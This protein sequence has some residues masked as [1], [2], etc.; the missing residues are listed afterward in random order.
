MK[1]A[2]DRPS[3]PTPF[4]CHPEPKAKDLVPEW[5]VSQR[6]SPDPSLR[7]APFRMTSHGLSWKPRQTCLALIVWILLLLVVSCAKKNGQTNTSADPKVTTLGSIEVTAR[8]E[9]IRG[10]LINDPLYDYAH[11]MKY[12]V[13]QVH[14]GK[15][16]KDIIYIGHYNPAKPRD[17]V[18]DARVQQIG[19]NVKQ[20]RVGDIHHMAL[21]VPIDDYYMGGIINKYFGEVNDPIYW[22]VWTNKAVK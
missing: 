17:A 6:R 14:R 7:F 4:S 22:A 12:K 1:M 2:Q 3:L 5:E 9:E 21:E 16:D 18:A 8:L 15:V 20:F 19:G 10:G 13:L 11:V